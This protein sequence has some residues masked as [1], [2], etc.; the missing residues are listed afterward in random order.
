MKLK[1]KENKEKN[2]VLRVFLLL[3]GNLKLFQMVVLEFYLCNYQARYNFELINFR[4]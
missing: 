2:C 4:D 1:V 3:N